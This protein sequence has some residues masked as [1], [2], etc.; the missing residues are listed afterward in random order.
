[1]IPSQCN[2][3]TQSGACHTALFGSAVRSE[4]H[5]TGTGEGSHAGVASV[6]M[7]DTA[8]LISSSS[9]NTAL[10][11]EQTDPE[12]QRCGSLERS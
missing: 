1:M 11:D 12:P 10:E 3:A 6:L 5:S 4:C 9:S 8:A 2:R 7:C